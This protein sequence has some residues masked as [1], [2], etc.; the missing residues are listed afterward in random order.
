MV[1][2]HGFRELARFL[3]CPKGEARRARRHGTLQAPH[4]PQVEPLVRPGAVRPRRSS[5]LVR[6]PRSR[7]LLRLQGAPDKPHRRTRR[8][9]RHP[10][11]D[12]SVD[13]QPRC[14]RAHDHHGRRSAR[15]GPVL[16]KDRPAHPPRQAEPARDRPLRRDVRARH[17]LGPRGS[18]QRRRHRPGAGDRDRDSVRAR[19][20][21]HRRSRHLRAPHRTGAPR[22]GADR[23]R[24]QGDAQ[25]PRPQVPGQGPGAQAGAEL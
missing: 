18:H 8:R 11:H 17:S 1:A 5:A 6:D 13:G 16:P 12:R 19:P 24:G 20:G 2:T 10:D 14:A 9:H 3:P 22:V 7:P 23:A 4:P 15:H 25:A 21:Q